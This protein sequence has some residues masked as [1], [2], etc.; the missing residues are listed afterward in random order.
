M[1]VSDAAVV[2]WNGS[3]DPFWSTPNNWGSGAVPTSADTASIGMVPGPVIAK[4][5]AVASIIWVG[6]GSALYQS[7]KKALPKTCAFDADCGPGFVCINGR[8][9]PAVS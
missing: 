2:P 9:I 4:E 8:C 6:A 3:A 5:G 7:R 1:G